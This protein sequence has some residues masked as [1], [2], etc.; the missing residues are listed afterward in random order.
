MTVAPEHQ[1]KILSVR[2]ME[3]IIIALEMQTS[4]HRATQWVCLIAFTESQLMNSSIKIIHSKRKHRIYEMANDAYYAEQK[5]IIAHAAKHFIEKRT[6]TS[7]MQFPES[8]ILASI[9]LIKSIELR[10]MAINP[11]IYIEIQCNTHTIT[12]ICSMR[13]HIRGTI[14][15]LVDFIVPEN[16]WKR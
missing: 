9:I 5:S 11:A 15:H 7:V 13:R 10:K 4:I 2:Q 1:P 3:L 16:L 6:E 14:S 12:M 8:N